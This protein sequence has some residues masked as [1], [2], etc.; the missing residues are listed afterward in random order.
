MNN[1]VIAVVVIVA[2]VLLAL[3]VADETSRR[4]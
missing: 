3:A 4:F 1:S 2:W